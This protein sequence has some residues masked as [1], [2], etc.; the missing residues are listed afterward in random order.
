MNVIIAGVVVILGTFQAQS[1]PSHDWVQCAVQDSQNC[2]I[3]STLNATTIAYGYT[4]VG[5]WTFLEVKNKGNPPGDM[6]IPCNDES[7]GN[8]YVPSPGKTC[9]YNPSGNTIAVDSEFDNEANWIL[10]GN[11]QD[12]TFQVP[13]KKGHSRWIRYGDNGQYVYR[14]FSY[15]VDCSSSL[16]GSFNSGNDNKCWYLNSIYDGNS[17]YLYHVV[18]KQIKNVI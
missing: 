17:S 6:I 8:V 4:P 15:Q 7:F 14:L 3:P 13:Y 2:V 18:V 10:A 12:P 9:C 16:F 11:S 5:I 1:C